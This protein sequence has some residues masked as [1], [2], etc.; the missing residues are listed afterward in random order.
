MTDALDHDLGGGVT[1]SWIEKDGV[2]VGLI[3]EHDH[4]ETIDGVVQPS[5]R[6]MGW[7][8]FRGLAIDTGTAWDITA[9]TAG[10]WDGLTLSPSIACKTCPNHGWIRDGRWVSA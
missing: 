5:R 9:G 8:P 1:A 6:N 4:V 3:E 2:I 10:V 7:V